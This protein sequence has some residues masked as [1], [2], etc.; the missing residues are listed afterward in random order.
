MNSNIKVTGDYTPCQGNSEDGIPEDNIIK[1][2]GDM[3]LSC[4]STH[5]MIPLMTDGVDSVYNYSYEKLGLNENTVLT[6]YLETIGILNPASILNLD[7]SSFTPTVNLD[8]SS[9][10]PTVTPILGSYNID[11][12]FEISHGIMDPTFTR[13]VEGGSLTGTVGFIFKEYIG[14]S[15]GDIIMSVPMIIEI[16]GKLYMSVLATT[17]T[18]TFVISDV[19]GP[20]VN[21]AIYELQGR[22]LV[23]QT[24]V[25]FTEVKP[26]PPVMDDGMELM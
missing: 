10:T 22:P 23:K 12:D 5:S 6:N 18:N 9:F 26:L 16:H 24:D 4:T 21:S 19:N 7:I 11:M 3:Y 1:K 17:G 20:T 2:L 14:K 15:G 25:N 13:T 8:I